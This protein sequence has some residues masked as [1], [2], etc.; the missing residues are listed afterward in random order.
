MVTRTLTELAAELGGDVV[1]DGATVIRGVAGI[2]E[3]LDGDI[4][5]IANSRYD[6]YLHETRASAIICSR[7][8]RAAVV[9]L[10]IVDNPYLAFQKVV[11]VF[12][13]DLHR[14]APGIHPT[15]LVAPD[16]ELGDEVSIGPH[17]VVEAGA[18]IGQRVVLCA[19]CY[20]GHHAAVGDDTFLHPRVTVR[21][22][23]VVGARCLIH[24]GVVIGSDGFGFA[25][26]QGRYH[27]VPQVGNVVI[28]DDVEIG[29]NTTIDRAT[30]A[31]TRIGDGT[32]IDNLVQ[33]G[34][35]VEIG[36][37]CIIVA[38]V[39]ISG[40]TVLEDFVTLGGQAGVGG[41]IRLGK[42]AIVGGKS[43]A[44]KSVPAGAIVTG[45]PAMRHSIWK[46]LS[47]L[48]QKLPELFQRTRDLE[49]RVSRI[50]HERERA[51]ER[52]SE[53]EEVR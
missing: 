38:Q 10:L 8:P 32:K 19:G 1:G 47:A 13:P 4:T 16:A 36:R 51:S 44:T 35:N 28:G 40:S 12:R 9:P 5:F 7:E 52:Q 3:A 25:L 17:A 30:T 37:H 43:G 15:A 11:R 6:A 20:L 23:C 14:P 42:G 18:R 45:F 27:K 31:S 46:R 48:I 2:R 24:P 34:H 21:E 50:E 49:E 29:A 33:I 41:H 22:D 39:G 53:R 26:D